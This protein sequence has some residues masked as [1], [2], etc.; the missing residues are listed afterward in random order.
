M[1]SRTRGFRDKR[2]CGQTDAQ[3][4]RLIAMGL[5]VGYSAPLLAAAHHSGVGKVRSSRV[6]GRNNFPVMA[7]IRT[8]GY[9]IL[10]CF[11]AT[12]PTYGVYG[13]L[14]HVG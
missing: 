3:T 13:H 2:A 6:P 5:H 12:L 4:D 9:H 10:E 7:K 8:S 1:V 11:A 14:V